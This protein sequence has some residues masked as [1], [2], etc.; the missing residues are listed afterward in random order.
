MRFEQ[1]LLKLKVVL[2]H[3]ITYYVWFEWNLCDHIRDDGGDDAVGDDD[4]DDDND[5]VE[6]DDGDDDVDGEMDETESGPTAW[7]G[8]RREAQL[9]A[10]LLLTWWTSA[11]EYC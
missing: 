1:E 5:A 9:A 10:A 11:P 3:L 4:D 2:L 7:C 8:R 6:D